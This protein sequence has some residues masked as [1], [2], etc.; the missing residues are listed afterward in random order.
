MIAAFLF[1]SVYSVGAV[2]IPL[3]TRYY[4]KA[5]NYSYAYSK[6]GFLTNV[7][8]SLSLALIG[9]LYDFTGTYQYVFL[10]A[11]VFHIVDICLIAGITLRN[12]KM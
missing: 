11:I 1:G 12:N 6:I 7:G 5:E 8:S 3:L 9:Y 4:F 10:L 2:G